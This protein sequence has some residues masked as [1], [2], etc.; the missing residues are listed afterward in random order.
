M[1]SVYSFAEYH[2]T[3]QEFK[4]NITKQVQS[5][6]NGIYV[7][8]EQNYQDWSIKENHTLAW[9]K[10]DFTPCG[11]KVVFKSL[12]DNSYT[13]IAQEDKNII[14]RLVGM[15]IK[16]VLISN[17][18]QLTLSNPKVLNEII[19]L[20]DLNNMTYGIDLSEESV[21]PLKGYLINPT[22]YRIDGPYQN[23]EIVRMWEEVD[24][25]IYIVVNKSTGE[26]VDKAAIAKSNNGQIIIRLKRALNSNEVLLFYPHVTYFNNF[27]LWQGYNEIRDNIQKYFTIRYSYT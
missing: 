3:K 27:D 17:N 9:E 5:L 21:N 6:T 7:D 12:E 13:S 24:S 2:G 1:I 4:N 23:M 26:I 19:E 8:K 10:E 16:D 14:N 22:R 18:N 20:L 11:I 15:G 25:G